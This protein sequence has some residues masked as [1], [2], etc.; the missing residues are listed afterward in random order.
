ME[1][2]NPRDRNTLTKVEARFGNTQRIEILLEEAIKN[3]P[4]A[5]KLYIWLGNVYLKNGKPSKVLNTLKP[6]LENYPKDQR[7]LSV[8]RRAELN[9]G[10]SGEAVAKFNDWAKLQSEEFSP[11]FYLA[12]A[13]EQSSQSTL[14][15][16]AIHT[17]LGLNPE[18]GSSKFIKARILVKAG[19]LEASNYLL[20]ESKQLNSDNS[21][22]TELQE[23]IS[24]TENQPQ[25]A[26]EYF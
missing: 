19:E 1:K 20:K 13:Y 24:L 5:V 25:Q 16:E 23:E 17:A 22:V 2:Y 8:L 9:T 14:A 18:R 6:L 12:K 11:H 21:W 10:N 7:A 15:R 3:E 26:I 4:D